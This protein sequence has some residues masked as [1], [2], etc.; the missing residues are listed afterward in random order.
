VSD[1]KKY[2]EDALVFTIDGPETRAFD[3]AI[4]L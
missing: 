2:L 3:D 1:R 4:S